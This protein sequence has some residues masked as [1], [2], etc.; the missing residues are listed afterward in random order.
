MI[1]AGL[2]KALDIARGE[3]GPARLHVAEGG[4]KTLLNTRALSQSEF[5]AYLHSA[6][7][8]GKE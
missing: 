6:V 2:S 5:A 3:A 1:A 7:K 4:E 8:Q